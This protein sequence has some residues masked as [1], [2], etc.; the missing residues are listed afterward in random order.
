MLQHYGIK[1]PRWLTQKERQDSR[2]QRAPPLEQRL[3]TAGAASLNLT[4]AY[5]NSA[6]EKPGGLSLS[7]RL[8]LFGAGLLFLGGVGCSASAAPSGEQQYDGA[9]TLTPTDSAQ[10]PQP[11]PTIDVSYYAPWPTA[12][13]PLIAWPTVAPLPTPSPQPPVPTPVK[14]FPIPTLVPTQVPPTPTPT[15]SL[16]ERARNVFEQF[17]FGNSSQVITSYDTVKPIVE[18][19]LQGTGLKYDNI[20]IY[21]QPNE[22]FAPNYC[23]SWQFSDIPACIT[24]LSNDLRDAG[25]AFTVGNVVWVKEGRFYQVIESSIRETL[26][27]VGQTN[28]NAKAVNIKA[29]K[30]PEVTGMLG[31][32]FANITLA[33][34]FGFDPFNDIADT[35]DSRARLGDFAFGKSETGFIKRASWLIFEDMGYLDRNKPGVMMTGQQAL[36]GYKRFVSMQD[37]EKYLNDLLANNDLQKDSEWVRRVLLFRLNPNKH[38][39]TESDRVA[40][41]NSDF[42]GAP[43]GKPNR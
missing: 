26:I 38:Q 20:E 33:E 41:F 3:A 16:E 2:R 24:D 37:P 25:L 27:S 23:D 10:S 17:N 29:V 31:A 32:S 13:P 9:A 40:F 19:V 42:Y 1:K 14:A 6:P 15:L 21:I 18:A 4:P 12:T 28:Y 36:E 34:K 7:A 11:T 39:P 22:K 5:Y 35:P 8:A 43:I 30:V